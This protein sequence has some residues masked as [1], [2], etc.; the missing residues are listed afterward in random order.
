M[1]TVVAIDGH[2]VSRLSERSRDQLLREASYLL[3]RADHYR[4]AAQILV[5][6]STSECDSAVVG[7][8]KLTNEAYRLEQCAAALKAEAK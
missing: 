7:A 5:L 4:N 6:M 3:Q 2:R 8:D 1:C